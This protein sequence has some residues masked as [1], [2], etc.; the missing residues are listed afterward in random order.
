[1]NRTRSPHGIESMAQ[2]GREAA[3]GFMRF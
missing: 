2:A 1:M 3:T